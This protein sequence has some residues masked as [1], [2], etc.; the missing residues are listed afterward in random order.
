MSLEWVHLLDFVV[1]AHA[2]CKG[3]DGS[4]NTDTLLLWLSLM[5]SS[6]SSLILH[7]QSRLEPSRSAA[8]SQAA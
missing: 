4:M 1:H 5:S 7:P 6:F 8:Q 3:T 2:E